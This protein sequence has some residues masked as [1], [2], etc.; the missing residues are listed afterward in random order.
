MIHLFQS[1][2]V[3][4]SGEENIDDLYLVPLPASS[5]TTSLSSLINRE[6]PSH[7]QL[8]TNT[9]FIHQ[10]GGGSWNQSKVKKERFNFGSDVQNNRRSNSPAIL[11]RTP[12]RPPPTLNDTLMPY[13][14]V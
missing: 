11:E 13:N 2:D 3:S 9:S 14:K 5:P 7:P 8:P 1:N 12:G 10:H 6:L 4:P